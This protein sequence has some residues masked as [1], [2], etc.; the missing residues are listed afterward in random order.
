MVEAATGPRG[1]QGRPGVNALIDGLNSVHKAGPA[2]GKTSDGYH[3]DKPKVSFN[4]G[5]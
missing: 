2:L 4:E 5:K 1:S 3:Y